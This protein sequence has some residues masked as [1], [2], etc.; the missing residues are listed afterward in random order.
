MPSKKPRIALTVPEEIKAVYDYTAEQMGV[1]TSQLIL[2]IMEDNADQVLQLGKAMELAK[3]DAE[4]GMSAMNKL[5][6]KARQDCA[7][8]QWDLEDQIA[9]KR[10][11]AKKAAKKTK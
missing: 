3:K 10:G 6:N 1:P 8:A 9:E 2:G 5:I 4:K 7:D 11:K